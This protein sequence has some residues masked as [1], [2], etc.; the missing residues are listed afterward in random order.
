MHYMIHVDIKEVH[1]K[2]PME[3]G[4]YPVKGVGGAV[5]M[6]ERRVLDRLSVVVSADTEAEA[7]RRVL[8]LLEVNRPVESVRNAK[9]PGELHS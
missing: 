6:T 8:A 7:Y 1:E 2:Q 3:S 9:V 4:G 5:Q